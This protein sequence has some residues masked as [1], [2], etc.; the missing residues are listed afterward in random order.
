MKTP[1]LFA[2][3]ATALVVALSGCTPTSAGDSAGGGKAPKQAVTALDW[4]VHYAKCMRDKG[5]EFPDPTEDGA[6]QGVQASPDKEPD[7]FQADLAACKESVTAKYGERPVTEK[8]RKAVAEDDKTNDCLRKNGVDVPDQ[9][10][11]SAEAT[12]TG[13]VPKSVLDEC[14]LDDQAPR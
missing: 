14:G 13:D 7:Q 1:L 10:G 3:A 8:D 12:Q 9:S 6:G 2:A 11:D 4:G 5:N